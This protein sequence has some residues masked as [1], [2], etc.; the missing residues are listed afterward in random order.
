MLCIYVGAG[1]VLRGPL[2]LMLVADVFILGCCSF[3]YILKSV[4]VYVDGSLLVSYACMVGLCA[5]GMVPCM[6]SFVWRG[7]SD[8]S[9][10]G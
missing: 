1:R 7:Y 9:T 6:G 3:V 10:L 2:C 5:P 8:T 4:G